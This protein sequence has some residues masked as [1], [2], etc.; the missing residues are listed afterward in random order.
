MKG[1]EGTLVPSKVMSELCGFV[2]VPLLTSPLP[3][4]NTSERCHRA[5]HVW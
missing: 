3:V 4:K 2:T 1:L 5:Q